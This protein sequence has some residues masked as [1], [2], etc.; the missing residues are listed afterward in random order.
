MIGNQY[1]YEAMAKCEQR[2]W[3]YRCLHDLTLSTIK[4][5]TPASHLRVLDA[6]CGTG[7][8]LMRLKENGFADI[9]GFDLSPDAVAYARQNSGVNVQLLDITHLQDAYAANYFDIIT[10]HDTVC[11]L[12][13][14][15]DS[16]A[17]AELLS[18]LKPG[19]F[20][21]MNF[22]ALKAFS[23]TH[24]IAVGIQKRYSIKAVKKL[25]QGM[26]SIKHI[27]Y[28]PFVLSPGIF[29]LRT[30]QKVKLLLK[31]NNGIS[32]VKMPPASLNHLLYTLTRLE[33][34]HLRIKPWGSSLFVVLQK[35]V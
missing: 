20:L 32:D 26:G 5:N 11:L 4:E 19:G 35:P 6:G 12:Q 13:Q 17:I 30:V 14:G 23:G 2:L 1:E 15:H 7:G 10:S 21:L 29:L 22:P 31:K 8:L 24:D 33:N 25:M 34:R 3:W 16:K 9:A 18:V 28:W 27:T